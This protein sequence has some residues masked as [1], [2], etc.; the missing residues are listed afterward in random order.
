MGE[1]GGAAS[2][3]N[4][5]GDSTRRLSMCR[6]LHPPQDRAGGPFLRNEF[7]AQQ[8]GCLKEGRRF[9]RLHQFLLTVRNDAVDGPVLGLKHALPRGQSLRPRRRGAH[10][11]GN[12][13]SS[14][15]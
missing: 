4:G 8:S 12:W 5:L 7:I 11:L 6:V 1:F 10:D 2:S 9:D 3:H 15:C 13:S 14:L